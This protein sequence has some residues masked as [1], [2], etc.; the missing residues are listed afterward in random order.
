MLFFALLICPAESK[1]PV[2]EILNTTVWRL[3]ISASVFVTTFA[4]GNVHASEQLIEK[5]GCISCHRVDQKLI[6]PSF[7]MVA[8]QYKGT[9]GAADYLFQKVREGGEGVWGDMPMT[10]NAPSKISDGDLNA[11]VAWIL[12]L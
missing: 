3:F 5:S 12:S 11:V 4:V 2:R 1:A 9:E 8:A 6:G 10:P 7:K